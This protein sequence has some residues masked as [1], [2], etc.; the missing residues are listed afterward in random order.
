[1]SEVPLLI[2]YIFGY[3]AGMVHETAG[4]RLQA[5]AEAFDKWLLF[6]K[7]TKL[8]GEQGRAK[9][10]WRELLLLS[11]KLPWE[12]KQ[13]DIEGFV[14]AQEKTDAARRTIC[15]RL[16]AISNFYKY[17][18]EH[19][20]DRKWGAPTVGRNY[21]NP[22]KGV[23]RPQRE[24]EERAGYLDEEEMNAFLRAIDKE[25]SIIGKRDYAFFFVLFLTAMN[26]TQL[27]RLRW[28]DVER[29]DDNV[30]IHV[31]PSRWK[32]KKHPEV[33][34]RIELGNEGWEAIYEYLKDSGRLSGMK[35]HYYVFAPMK[36]PLLHAPTGLASDWRENKAMSRE[37]LKMM[38]K[39]YAKSAGLDHSKI[40]YHC[41]RYTAI[42]RRLEAGEDEKDIQEFLGNEGLD[43][44]KRMIKK[45]TSHP[46]EPMWSD[47]PSFQIRRG[48]HRFK[49]GIAYGLTHGLYQKDSIDYRLVVGNEKAQTNEVEVEEGCSIKPVTK[50]SLLAELE[51]PADSIVDEIAKLR[52]VMDRVFKMMEK[53]ETVEQGIRLMDAY[54][55]ALSRLST[56]VSTQ[57]K[58]PNFKTKFDNLVDIVI[59]QINEE[60]EQK[61]REYREGVPPG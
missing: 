47:E 43:S 3:E 5:W 36:N 38:I 41:I 34:R 55:K 13:E 29:G 15:K 19:Q 2:Y 22:A 58:L 12:I 46:H 10:A 37:S 24:A 54:G 27:A 51:G 39:R 28:L 4:E 6:L 7:N 16:T 60:D 32:E 1:M 61:A 18:Y 23:T 59:Q 48:P 49:N 42:V 21:L 8:R 25:G 9:T 52:A 14:V 31:F 35:S 44:T 45:L 26:G 40:K 30:W 33:A 56:S 20:V 11:P 57:A 50:E 53:L 17:V